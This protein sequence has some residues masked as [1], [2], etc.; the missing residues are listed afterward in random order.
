MSEGQAQLRELA[1]GFAATAEKF[2]GRDDMGIDE[3]AVAPLIIV[4]AAMLDW[5]E[6]ANLPDEDALVVANN[7]ALAQ[8]HYE[9][10]ARN[11]GEAQRAAV[12]MISGSLEVFPT[13]LRGVMKRDDLEVPLAEHL[14]SIRT[15][16]EESNRSLAVMTYVTG[17]A[18]K[19]D[20]ILEKAQDAAREAREAAS[21]AKKA[22]TEGATNALERSFQTTAKSSA[23]AAFWFRVGTL[24]TL[25]AAA[26][27]GVFYAVDAPN[28]SHDDWR[29]IVYR[30]AIL[31]A[32]GAIAAYLGRQAGNYHRIATWAQAI[33]IQLKAFLGFVNEI[34]DPEARQTMYALFGKRVLDAPPDSKG[35]GDEVTNLIQPVVEQAARIRSGS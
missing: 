9:I 28:H 16:R 14:A 33:E 24:A 32:L 26:V 7:A 30:I 29:A 2:R 13:L 11:K 1:R 10:W 22:A 6:K 27:L 31:S 8:Q 19:S 20:E 18:A 5:A 25:L 4:W 35:G 3:F 17:R 15:A 23:R 12:L 21:L 34:E